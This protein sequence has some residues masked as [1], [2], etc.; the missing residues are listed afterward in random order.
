MGVEMRGSD[1]ENIE[2]Y[3]ELADF[4]K[5]FGDP[6][7]L[8][9]LVLLGNGEAKVT[10]ISEKIHMTQSAVSHQLRI[11]K[12]SRIVKLRKDGKCAFYTFDDDHIGKILKTGLD[13]ILEGKK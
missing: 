8:K 6:T 9:I 3:S 4:F 2:V 1:P 5:I 12:Q 13:H 11:L 7:R 10:D